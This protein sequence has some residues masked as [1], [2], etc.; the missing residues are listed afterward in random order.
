[1]KWN[2][3]SVLNV[4]GRTKYLDD[5]GEPKGMLHAYPVTAPCA[6][7]K[8]LGLDASAALAL[9]PAVRIVT[10]D[11]VP[12]ENQLGTAVDDEEALVPVGHEWV[13][14]GETLALA[15]APTPLLARRAA[16]AVK[17]AYEELEP[18]FDPLE[19]FKLGRLILKPRTIRCG[20][21]EAAF[22][23]CAHVFE[24]KVRSGGQEHVY[25]EPQ[26][27]IA[28]PGE[29]GRMHLL[30]GTQSPTGVQKAVARVLG[31]PMHLVECEAPR[32][33]GAFGGK[34]DQAA[35][36]AALAAIAAR[37][38]DAPVKIYLRRRDDMRVSGKRHPYVSTY[39]IGLDADLRIVAYEADFYQNSGACADLS[40]A[41]L[42]RTLFHAASAY[43]IPNVRVT[44]YM[45]RTN[46]VPFTAFRGFGAPQGVFV[47]ESAI[48]RAAEALGVRALDIQRKNLLKPGDSFHYGMPVKECRTA[49]AMEKALRM[50]GYDALVKEIEAYNASHAATKRGIAVMPT[51]FGI[52]FTKLMMNQGG[53][54]VHVYQD[55]S[56][57]VSSGGIEMG[58]GLNRKIAV[59]AS[60]SLGIPIDAV[61]IERTGT[62]TV[63]NTFPTAASSGSDINGAA[64]KAAC[65]R[66]VARLLDFAR[67][68]GGKPG[69]PEAAA[70][71]ASALDIVDGKLLAD[72]R[73][74]GIDWR[75]LVWKA[76]EARVDL[77]EHGFFATPGLAYDMGIERGS[78]FAYHVFGAA[79]V[80]A[81]LDVAR[82]TYRFDRAYICHDAGETLDE[83][84]DLGQIEGA[85]AQGLG[86][87]AL[88]ELAFDDRGRVASDTLSTYKLPDQRFM[89]EMEC[90]LLRDAPNPF[91]VMNSK[92]I[93]EPPFIYGIAG[94]FAALDALRAARPGKG[95][96]Y[97]LPMTA[98]K[99]LGFLEGGFTA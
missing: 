19:A 57:S 28:T 69:L 67:G 1:M 17:P 8:L 79:V 47:I 60:R 12:G 29:G 92:A 33:G 91:A 3:D 89:P 87:A 50:S 98:E 52:S 26:G 66:I 23:G 75:T 2:P 77:S 30:S 84:V 42:P 58:Q 32:L 27:A 40:P 43:R 6:R 16:A 86:W 24:G 25:L 49:E 95:G 82:G 72:G 88:E 20:D 81:T 15:V 9:D 76:H 31:A 97:D 64:V 71:S 5:L 70:A 99:A 22:A 34:E 78:P 14:H 37:K 62:R 11:D 55:G 10:A 94:Y 7:G 68:E 65:D 41:I 39:R 45:C 35:P 56:V 80:T 85:F 38:L 61:R 54:L 46:L 96:F 48:E 51:C 90:E 53:A 4:L 93:G 44:G 59:V 83:I 21:V 74:T 18:V 73:D 36:W 13:Y 63:A